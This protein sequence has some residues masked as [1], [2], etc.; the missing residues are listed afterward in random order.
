MTNQEYDLNKMLSTIEF[1]IS[2]LQKTGSMFNQLSE[3]ERKIRDEKNC[4]ER[5]AVLQKKD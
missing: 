3:L 5:S 2:E 4:L 1:Q